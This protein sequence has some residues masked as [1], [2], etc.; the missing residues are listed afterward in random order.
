MRTREAKTGFAYEGTPEW[1][2][3]ES[4]KQG[5]EDVSTIW[6]N[7]VAAMYEKRE[8]ARIIGLQGGRISGQ[9]RTQ[10]DITAQQGSYART[11]GYYGGASA[12]LQGGANA[13]YINAMYPRTP[14]TGYAAGG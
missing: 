11:A 14:T 3:A 12:L 4:V 8:E 10:G 7:T 9:L 13:M 2:A 5:E 6:S 1:V